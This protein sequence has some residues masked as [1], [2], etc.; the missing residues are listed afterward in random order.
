M[1][2]LS[3]LAKLLIVF[4][5]F[6][7]AAVIALAFL[8]AARNETIGV[9]AKEQTG[10]EYL[11]VLR[12]LRQAIPEYRRLRAASPGDENVA[13]K[14]TEIDLDVM[15]LDEADLRVGPELD[16]TEDFVKLRT[17]WQQF[18]GGQ[19]APGS[20]ETTG[21][22]NPDLGSRLDI[23]MRSL[24]ALVGDNSGLTLDPVLDTYYL[25]DASVV[26]LSNIAELLNRLI[27][28][29][30][31]FTAGAILP[32]AKRDEL[33]ITAAALRTDLGNLNSGLGLATTFKP[34]LLATLE[35]PRQEFDRAARSMLEILDRDAIQ[36]PRLAA[37]GDAFAMPLAEALAR[38]FILDD[39]AMTL[40]DHRLQ[41]RVDEAASS[42]DR[43]IA[44]VSLV[45][46]VGLLMA[47][48]VALSVSRRLKWLREDV[49][50]A[51]AGQRQ[52]AIG[53]PSDDEIGV[54]TEA[55]NRLVESR[56]GARGAGGGQAP[57]D[58]LDEN[59][60]LKDLVADLSLE[61]HALR[62]FGGAR[63]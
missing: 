49:A 56:A 38:S 32:Q 8:T 48:W 3:I 46:V 57:A 12:P 11:E 7:A 1:K 35:M 5:L 25:M 6:A 43:A 27:D 37:R 13:R 24:N 62:T 4:G 58:L 40:L 55:V 52:G 31:S 42:R 60:R 50:Q 36:P 15:R 63:T 53:T 39:A 51:A 41:E 59:R 20:V 54:L 45:G 9:T 29:T 61:N 16:T 14:K 30:R 10:V 22:G 28:Q 23:A 2:Q 44:Y 18:T 34:S 21:E 26:K 47:V 17:L 33:V 19:L